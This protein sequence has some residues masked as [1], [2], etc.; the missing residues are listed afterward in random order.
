VRP[1]QTRRDQL[2]QRLARIHA[3][4]ESGGAR[5][6]N[7]TAR[8]EGSFIGSNLVADRTNGTV[9]KGGYPSRLMIHG[10][11]KAE[12]C[13][14]KQRTKAKLAT[15]TVANATNHDMTTAQL[16]TRRTSCKSIVVRHAA[17]R[18]FRGLA[19]RLLT[20][21][22][23]PRSK[24]AKQQSMLVLLVRYGQCRNAPR[25]SYLRPLNNSAGQQRASGVCSPD[26][27]T[28]T[29]PELEKIGQRINSAEK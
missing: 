23:R 5:E 12:R 8:S 2:Q 4:S 9:R 14:S 29:C 1:A 13:L 17:A 22:G 24:D 27:F 15:Q 16:D 25:R 26:S 3:V 18:P 11:V 28:I 19:A 20:A 21:E 7:C 10:P 6:I